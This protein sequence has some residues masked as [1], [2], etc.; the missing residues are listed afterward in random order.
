MKL[1][2]KFK[3]II[4]GSLF[5]ASFFV[6]NSILKTLLSMFGIELFELPLIPRQLLAIAIS[7]VMP[8][9][10]IITY[11][12]ELKNDLKKIKDNYRKY[13]EISVLAYA[14]G[15]V[16]MM[17]SNIIIQNLF[18][19]SLAENEQSV[20]T[21]LDTLPIYMVAVT[22]L[23]GPFNEEMVFRKIFKDIINNKIL[24]VITS[25]LIFGLLHV[26]GVDI[27]SIG[28]LFFIPYGI[29][30]G[31]FAYVYAKTDNI[32]I[33]II[34]HIIHNTLLVS[35]QLLGWYKWKKELTNIKKAN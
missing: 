24:F 29:L 28:F 19:H 11:K 12:K 6:L 34:I 30:G 22:C 9:L 8:I 18:T 33:P 26:S 27:T 4:Y 31:T 5:I 20:R 32:W 35:I 3:K 16:L 1:D 10:M 7:L 15:M 13:I 17:V 25:G 23:I 21:A 14:I 2:D